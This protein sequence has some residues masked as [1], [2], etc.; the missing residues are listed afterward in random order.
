[1]K[2]PEQRCF[3]DHNNNHR[4]NY[5]QKLPEVQ[6]RSDIIVLHIVG[7]Q[8]NGLQE[9][10]NFSVPERYRAEKSEQKESDLS[11]K[12]TFRPVSVQGSESERHSWK[13]QSQDLKYSKTDRVH[14]KGKL[15][16]TVQPVLLQ[17]YGLRKYG[18][19]IRERGLQDRQM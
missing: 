11:G 6:E 9:K 19:R 5:G 16:D 3:A 15:T 8:G 14:R 13:W 1:M 7:L 17:K 18:K 10:R 2:W 4:Y 12:S